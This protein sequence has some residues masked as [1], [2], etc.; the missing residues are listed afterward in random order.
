MTHETE[1]QHSIFTVHAHF[2]KEW[3]WEF[4]S[5]WEWKQVSIKDLSAWTE[6]DFDLYNPINWLERWAH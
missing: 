5:E 2:Q 6:T 4:C 3:E 1:N